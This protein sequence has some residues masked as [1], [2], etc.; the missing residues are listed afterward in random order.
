MDCLAYRGRAEVL[1]KR[2][3]GRYE[4]ETPTGRHRVKPEHCRDLAPQAGP[5]PELERLLTSP[6]YVRPEPA[7]PQPKPETS[8]MPAYLAW[9]R[10]QPC[11]RCGTREGVEASHHNEQGHGTMGRK[12]PDARA[13]PLCARDHRLFHSDPARFPR[14]WIDSVIAAHTRAWVRSL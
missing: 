7:P 1:R 9:L 14:D 12:P 8:R 3:D 13:I 2:D 10:R 4:V 11:A 5:S 6:V